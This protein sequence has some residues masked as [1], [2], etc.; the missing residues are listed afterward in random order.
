ML[1]ELLP[2]YERE[3]T[4]LR[5]LAKEFA[6]EYPKIAGRLKIDGEVCEDPHVNRLI[7]AF[8]FLAARV[9]KKLDDEFPEIT[10]ALLGML[11]PHYLR[12]IPSMAIVQ[13]NVDPDQIQ[14]TG[15][16]TV[17]RHTMLFSREVKGMPCKF[18]T[19]YPLEL[20]PVKITHAQFFPTGASAFNRLAEDTAATLQIR[21]TCIGEMNWQKLKLELLKPSSQ[22]EPRTTPKLRLYLA[23]ETPTQ[24]ALYEILNNNIQQ[25]G[26]SAAKDR[27]IE[28]PSDSL[29]PVGFESDE[30]LLDYEPR[31]FIGYRLLHEYF[32]FPN[33]FMFFDL[34]NLDKI[35]SSF[36][37]ELTITFYFSDF[38]RSEHMKRLEQAVQADTF[39]LGCTPIINLFKQQ[40]E[41][42]NLT[43]QKTEYLVIPDVR[44]PWGTEVYSVDHVRKITRLRDQEEVIDFHPFYSVKHAYDTTSQQGTYW[45][46]NRHATLYKD[47]SGTDVFLSLVDLNFDPKV[48]QIETLSIGITCTNRDLPA[49]L[50]FGGNESDFQLDGYPVISSVRCLTKPTETL[51][52]PL[53]NS[54]RWRL[55][56]HLALNHLSLI[57]D[58]REALL[59]ILNLYNFTDSEAVK[60]QINGI[61]EV[62]SRSCVRRIHQNMRFALV[63]GNEIKLDF[64][65]EQFTGSGVYLFASVLSHFFGLYSGLNSF[66]Q[67]TV[68]SK[69]REGELARWQPRSGEA[70][71]V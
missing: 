10:D 48:P 5:Q 60:K 47:G 33:K 37:K 44:R 36:D 43:H 69:Q 26:L 21:L 7:E 4:Y 23:G 40:A 30:S 39:R 58:G 24:H 6:N 42:I 34:Y 68:T 49:K 70:A 52:P 2:Y 3:L 62:K 59:E 71:I 19:C 56:S 63:Q 46:A 9:H 57:E 16:Y 32:S 14:M 35:D 15:P 17:P 65:E 25:I 50:P 20:W 41:P 38:Q 61:L 1:Q 55:I 18:R 11:Y 13:L 28:I 64:D 8:S 67:L 22:D 54:A 29:Q 66:T 53:R 12:P 51:R 31:S 45:C 27:H